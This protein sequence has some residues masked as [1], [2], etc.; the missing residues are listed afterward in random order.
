MLDNAH[1]NFSLDNLPND[2]VQLKTIILQQQSK[3]LHLE[4]QFR[5]AQQ[6]QFGK[7][8]EGHVSQ[9]EVFNEAEAEIVE[10]T[11]DKTDTS[12]GKKPKRKPLPTDLLREVVTHD[13]SDTDK[14]CECWVVSC[15]KSVMKEAKSSSLSRLKSKLLNMYA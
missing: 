3:L 13:I 15:I 10:S 6:K 11:E 5:L 12:S 1:M 9:D 8:A 7:S 14:T 4:E 2:T